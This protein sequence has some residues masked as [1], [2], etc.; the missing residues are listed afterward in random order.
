MEKI[1]YISILVLSLAVFFHFNSF[2]FGPIHGG[3]LY[4]FSFLLMMVYSI[5]QLNKGES[6][7]KY[8]T[9]LIISFSSAAQVWYL[10]IGPITSELLIIVIC[11]PLVAVYSILKIF[12]N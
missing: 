10:Q 7:F 4:T 5:V 3:H 2:V 9:L 1:K 8:L 6:K 11:C 12:R